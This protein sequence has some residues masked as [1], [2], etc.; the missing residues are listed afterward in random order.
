MSEE[1]KIILKAQF[2]PVLKTYLFLIV[3]WWSFVSFIGIPII[4]I[5]LFVGMFFCTR[6]FNRLECNLTEHTL[7][8]K[9]GYLFRVEKTIPLDKIQD[10]TLREG[11]LL[12]ALNLG[13]LDIETAGQS[14]AQGSSDAKIVGIIDLK[15]FRN[16]VLKQRDIVLL[17][18]SK[19]Q[20]EYRSEDSSSSSILEQIR[21]TLVRIEKKLK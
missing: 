3:T 18:T 21:D 12:R 16:R 13:M 6:Y 7:E 9:K 5:W 17:H 19:N 10:L 2:H 1:T 11:P 15:E 4:P 8:L 14:G 20:N